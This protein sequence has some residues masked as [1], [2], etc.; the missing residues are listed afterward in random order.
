MAIDGC[1]NTFAE[2]AATVLP[3]HM[4]NMH[5][6]IQHPRALAEFCIPGA[7]IKTVAKRL[8]RTA[9]F[10]GCYVIL[11]GN[12]PFHVGISRGV[13]GRLRQHGTGGTQFDAAA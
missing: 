2:L 11:R 6:A 8:G 10:S 13:I 1:S 12:S 7:G 4:E 5:R 3:K 9:D